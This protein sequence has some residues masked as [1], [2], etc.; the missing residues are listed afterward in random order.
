MSNFKSY[1]VCFFP[2][3]ITNYYLHNKG[4]RGV[5]LNSGFNVLNERMYMGN[6]T[7]VNVAS[8]VIVLQSLSSSTNYSGVSES[9]ILATQLYDLYIHRL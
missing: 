9:C 6:K 5:M 7:R 1:V 4:D 2:P 8:D 3:L